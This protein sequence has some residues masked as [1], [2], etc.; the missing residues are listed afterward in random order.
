MATG[1]S[2]PTNYARRRRKIV[3][4]N[5]AVSLAADRTVSVRNQAPALCLRDF[6]AAHSAVA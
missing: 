1:N 6:R 2:D 3:T 5:L 4:V